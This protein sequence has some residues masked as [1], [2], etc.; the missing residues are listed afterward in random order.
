MRL[1]VD[2]DVQGGTQSSGESDS[3]V[4]AGVTDG[5]CVVFMCSRPMICDVCGLPRSAFVNRMG[6]T[7]CYG[8]SSE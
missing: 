3:T 8:C 2:G 1:L 7:S 6:S 5:D 4:V